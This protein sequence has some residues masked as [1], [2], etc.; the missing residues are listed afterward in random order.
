MSAPQAAIFAMGC[1]WQPD[2]YFRKLP[3]VLSTEVGYIGGKVP[4]PSYERVCTGVS[5]HAEAVRIQFDPAR[6]SYAALLNEFWENHDPTTLNSQGPDFG[7]QYRSAIFCA[8]QAQL[9]EA[10]ASRD[11]VA[12]EGLWGPDPITT[13]IQLAPEFWPAED[14]HQKYLMKRGITQ[15]HLPSP[16]RGRKA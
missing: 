15:C 3:G 4:K 11:R 6:T 5:G 13:A 14:Y 8:D 9:D 16:P 7:E 10:K 12:K 1:F 2:E